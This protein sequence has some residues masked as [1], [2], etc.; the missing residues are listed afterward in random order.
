M[1]NDEDN[2]SLNS[3]NFKMYLGAAGHHSF[4]LDREVRMHYVS[5]ESDLLF[6]PYT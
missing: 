5:S 4:G 3:V 2:T 6:Y 1:E